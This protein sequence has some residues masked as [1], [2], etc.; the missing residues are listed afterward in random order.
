MQTEPRY[1]TRWAGRLNTMSPLPDLVSDTVWGQMQVRALQREAL[2]LEAVQQT[3][4]VHLDD[5]VW[6]Q[7]TDTHGATHEGLACWWR[8]PEGN[9]L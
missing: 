3:D 2:A 4:F 8:R 5:L 6:V 1:S 7:Y 9:E